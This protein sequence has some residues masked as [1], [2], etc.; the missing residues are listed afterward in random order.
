MNRN[1]KSTEQN[2]PKCDARTCP[3]LRST[4]SMHARLPPTQACRSPTRIR[5]R[6]LLACLQRA[7]RSQHAPRPHTLPLAR[8]EPLAYQPAR[9]R[10]PL[11]GPRVRSR[12]QLLTRVRSMHRLMLASPHAL[13]LESLFMAVLGVGGGNEDFSC[14]VMLQY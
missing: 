11:L 1:R 3:H 7:A 12:L 9:A 6:R 14:L 8:N 2:R 10:P 5:A 4:A 13:G